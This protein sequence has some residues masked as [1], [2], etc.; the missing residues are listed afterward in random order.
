MGRHETGEP[1][2]RIG[3]QH[4]P[5]RADRRHRALDVDEHSLDRPDHPRLGLITVFL[6]HHTN[7]WPTNEGDKILPAFREA[8]EKLLG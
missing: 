2:A 3:E 1:R 6:I 7:D 4:V 8:A 5:H